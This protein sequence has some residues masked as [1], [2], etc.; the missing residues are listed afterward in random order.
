MCGGDAI[1]DQLHV[2]V[3]GVLPSPSISLELDLWK[4]EPLP[5]L[6]DVDPIAVAPL[7]YVE[8]LS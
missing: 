8:M 1:S 5:S 4:R 7:D 6:S 2:V 3:E